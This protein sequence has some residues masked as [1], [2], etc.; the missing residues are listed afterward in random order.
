MSETSPERPAGWDVQDEAWA[1]AER[2]HWIRHARGGSVDAEG[3]RERRAEGLAFGGADAERVV[4]RAEVWS[5]WRLVRDADGPVVREHGAGRKRSGSFYTPAALALA[6]ARRTLAPLLSDG[7][8]APRP[9]AELL[10]LRV[11]D[12]SCGSGAFLV[13]ALE[14]LTDALEASVERHRDETLA[15]EAL[16]TDRQVR[17]PQLAR[18]ATRA[19]YGV[20]RDRG[21]VAAARVALAAAA[22]VGAQSDVDVGSLDGVGEEAV[23]GSANHV[24]SAAGGTQ[25]STAA[26]GHGPPADGSARIPSA[27]AIEARLVCG[28]ALVGSFPSDGGYP[29]RAFERRGGDED[30]PTGLAH[31]PGRFAAALAERLAQTP[32]PGPSGVVPIKDPDLRD[33]WVALWFWPAERLEL[34]PRAEDFTTAPA[35]ARALAREVC[36]DLRVLHWDLA[37]PD[38][39]ARGGFDAVLGNPPWETVKGIARE[40][41]GAVDE[42]YLELG[43]REARGRR[44]ELFAADPQLEARWIELRARDAAY[45]HWCRAAGR[46]Q[47]AERAA[48]PFQHRGTGDLNGYK[49]FLELG[50]TLL[51]E[52]GRLGMV[53]PGALY[54]DRGTRS[55]R[56]LLLDRCRWEWLYA[57]DNRDGIFPIHK[58]YKFCVAIATRGGS[59]RAVRAAFAQASLDDWSGAASAAERYPRELIERTSPHASAFLELGP[60]RDLEL[61]EKLAATGQPL[62]DAQGW[63]LV[64]STELHMSADARLFRSAQDLR[65]RGMVQRA[66]GTWTAP[67]GERALPVLQGAMIGQHAANAAGYVSGSGQRARFER[68]ANLLAP[69]V[70]QHFVFESELRAR[71]AEAPG[72]KLAYRRIAPATNARTLIAAVTGGWVTGDSLFLFAP[73][74]PDP[75]RVLCL[76][77]LFNSF[78][79][80]W[81]VRLRL[82]GVNLSRFVLEEVSLPPWSEIEPRA[83]EL[84]TIAAR[85]GLVG[86]VAQAARPLAPDWVAR[87]EAEPVV[88]D[89][90][91]RRLRARLDRAVAEL[92]GLDDGDLAWILRD[93]AHAAPDLARR[94]FVRQLAPKGFWRVDRELEPS[95]RLTGLVL[96]DRQ[97]GSC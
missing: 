46:S 81:Q 44:S 58:S 56:R 92:F 79:L 12:P 54:C 57:F 78:V 4:R 71:G 50:Y 15:G 8:G 90:A 93:C 25:G 88:T 21:A 84:A 5:S 22:G 91:R 64:F 97:P 3:L 2:E 10:E 14:V 36:A 72:L 95:E 86:A 1:E 32:R 94:R 16:A 13:A 75:R 40:F 59:T 70:P 37:F 41:F 48:R 63:D 55:L 77:A 31:L 69:P 29:R 9:A 49:L 47:S 7:E 39:H 24:S 65:S 83:G 42:D 60:R 52:G 67:D 66:D 28:D 27:A 30:H 74:E 53:V 96:A 33:L 80:D 43:A 38:V 51:R 68:H 17:R 87:A 11:C 45:A 18:L 34:A 35:A 62:A 82:G 73:R 26:A 76:A 6:T 89:A 23:L 85:L 61:L 19:L 20:D